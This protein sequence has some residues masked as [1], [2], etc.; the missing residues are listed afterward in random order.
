MVA[1]AGLV[2]AAAQLQLGERYPTTEV[3]HRAVAQLRSTP[4]AQ[5][6]S[7][8]IGPVALPVKPAQVR[9]HGQPQAFGGAAEV[10]EVLG[11]QWV[12]ELMR[13]L[14]QLVGAQLQQQATG[15]GGG[16]GGGVGAGGGR[17][18]RRHLT[19]MRWAAL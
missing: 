2:V 13:H 5:V 6:R 19:A 18:G 10:H 4:L 16:G 7:E 11:P 3:S 15:G 12:A 1:D 9:L 8:D 14:A 17:L